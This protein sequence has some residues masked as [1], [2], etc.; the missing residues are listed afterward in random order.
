M[1]A[2]LLLALTAGQ[3]AAAPY[4]PADWSALPALRFARRPDPPVALNGF[5]RGEIAA[6][7]CVLS[8]TTSTLHLGLA[9]LV[10]D[11]AAVRILPRAIGC[12]TVEQFAAGLLSGLARGRLD[13]ACAAGWYRTTLDVALER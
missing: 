4:P 9:V 6:G 2:A 11:G 13:G 12:P 1:I 8:R 3:L 10:A 5:V 7:R